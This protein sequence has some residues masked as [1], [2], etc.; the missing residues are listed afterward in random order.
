[1]IIEKILGNVHD[2]D[3]AEIEKRHIEKVNLESS[4]LVKRVQRLKTDHNRDIGVR[5]STPKDLK[6]GDI[7]FMNDRSMIIIDV[8]SDD[9]LVIQPN[10]IQEMGVIAHELGNRHM[11][12]KFEGNEMLVQ[13]D[14][15]VEE[16]LKTKG[17]PFKR[18]DRKVKDAF[19]H[20]TGAHS[21]G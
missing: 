2:M 11:P 15:L 1:M 3:N 6:D 16:L 20:I 19:R 5:L 8:K 10:D 13:Y 9:L 7:L 17:I 4:D 18:E 14:Y 21:H 12:A